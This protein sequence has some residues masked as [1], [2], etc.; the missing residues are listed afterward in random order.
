[1][2]SRPLLYAHFMAGMHAFV[3]SVSIILRSKGFIASIDGTFERFFVIKVQ[4]P[5]LSETEPCFQH[6]MTSGIIASESVVRAVSDG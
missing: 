4:F 5:V 3:M 6:F 1:V 2:T